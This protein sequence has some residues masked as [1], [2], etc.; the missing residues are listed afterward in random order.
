MDGLEERRK[1]L[2]GK[3]RLVHKYPFTKAQSQLNVYAD[4]DWAAADTNM[5]STSG[6]VVMYGPCTVK[7][8]SST[9]TV[10]ALSSA[11]AKLYALV[12]AATQAMG[13]LSMADDFAMSTQAIVH[14]DSSSALSICH[15]KGLGGKTRHIGMRHSWVQ[16]ALANKDFQLRKVLG[17]DNPADRMTKHFS[18][19]DI[20]KHLEAMNI[21]FKEGRPETAAQI[22]SGRGEQHN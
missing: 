3:P 19:G 20:C 16:N 15:R 11:E 4:S 10:V 14:T 17:A 5:K 1:I 8:W 6:G 7:T 18:L 9:Q 2:E 13:I 21:E 22:K 12:K